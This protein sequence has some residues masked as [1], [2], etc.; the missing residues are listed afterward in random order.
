MITII[1]ITKIPV[2]LQPPVIDV[3]CTFHLIPKD[4]VWRTLFKNRKANIYIYIDTRELDIL[5]L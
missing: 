5:Y 2:Q 1:V 4:Q 3:K